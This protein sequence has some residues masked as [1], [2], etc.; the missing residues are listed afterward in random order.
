MVVEEAWLQEYKSLLTLYLQSGNRGRQRL[1][2]SWLLAFHRVSDPSLCGWYQS[3]LD[4]I[5]PSQLT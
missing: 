4:Q 3:H 1:V 2:L 5:F